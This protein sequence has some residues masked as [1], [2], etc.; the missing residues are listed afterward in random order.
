MDN[1]LCRD[2]FNHVLA[3]SQVLG[4]NLPDIT[5]ITALLS[6]LP[7]EQ[8]GSGG[9]LQEWLEDVDA[10][11]D[12]GHRHCSHLVGFF[13]GDEISTYYTPATAA[14]A[15]HSVD[16]RGYANSALTPWSCSWRFCLRDRLQDGD[17]AWT[18]LLFL[19]GYNK[20][21][22]NLIF[23]DAANEQLDSVFGRLAGIAGMFLQSPRGE[24]I[25]LPALPTQLTN[26]MVSGLCAA[27]GFEVDNLTWS[28]GQ[29]TGATILSK[30]GNVCNLRTKWPI[31][32]EQGN[33]PVSAPMV[34]PGLYQFATTAGSN[35]TI[36][37]ATI[38]EAENLS[39]TTSGATQQI[40][41]NAAL[42]NWRASQFNATAP[43]NSVTYLVPNVAAGNYHLYLVANA[44]TN[45]G[46]F[47][48]SCGPSGGPL[49]SVG[50]VQDTY[51]PTNVVYLLPIKVTT[52]IN[53]IGLWANMQTEFDCGNWTAP[54]N[55]NYSF[56]LTVTGKNAGSSGYVLTPDY[57]KFAPAAAA[58][59]PT[60]N[61]PLAPTNLV[62]ADGAS[63]Q[64][65]A[66][67]LQASAF[68]DPDAGDTQAASEWLVQQLSDNTVVFDSG[69]DAVDT[70]SITLPP[71]TLNFGT[72]YTWQVRY[73]DNHG[74]WSDYSATTTF[75]TAN[76]A[77]A[78]N[79]SAGG[80][81]I[82][83]PTN[84]A[85]FVL[86]YSTNLADA[87]WMPVGITPSVVN[88]FKV[89][90]NPPTADSMFFRLDKP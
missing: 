28:N 60:N 7:P 21:A 25:L 66:P 30:V 41:T 24:I 48:L 8:V 3:A 75:S 68:T 51:S 11:Y 46:Q 47:Q 50:S 16:L 85:N 69:T 33:N 38:A 73:E 43:G 83:W 45:C 2:L 53:V 67:T 9:Q 13:P 29:F 54:S 42:S 39:A 79:P 87:V 65:T 44:G 20:V 77:M 52:P 27:G 56:Q 17:G 15:K 70:A 81:V 22:T 23:A 86:E 88:G 61:P 37:P 80:L 76:P 59:I 14:A 26:G 72:S 55:G 74:T 62:P 90:T 4:T 63:S 89:V 57:I 71:G 82:S 64:T 31:V 84:S 36:L 10:T 34:L 32:V 12:S 35:Y 1:E 19:Y 40:I 58:I 6:E 49:T 5:N 78:F 18:N